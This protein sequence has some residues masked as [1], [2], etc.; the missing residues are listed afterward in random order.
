MVKNNDTI[1]KETIL[2]IIHFFK[3]LPSDWFNCIFSNLSFTI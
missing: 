2:F 3:F 1:A